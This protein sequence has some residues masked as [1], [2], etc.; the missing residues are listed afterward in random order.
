MFGLEQLDAEAVYRRLPIQL[1]NL[2]C[3]FVGWRTERTR[4]S[5]AF[6][7]IL[8]E[9]VARTYWTTDET[10]SFRSRRLGSLVKTC[11]RTVPF[12]R[13]RLRAAGIAASDIRSIEDL[14]ALPI[15][16]KDE[17]REHLLKLPPTTV[18]SR[19]TRA[20]HTSGTTGAGLRFRTTMV[21]IQEQW[22]IWWRYRGWH[23]IERRTWCGLFGGRSVVP[24]TQKSPPFWRFN[25]AGRQ[26]LF[27]GYHISPENLPAYAAELRRRQP[28]WLHG[29]PSLWTHIPILAT[30]FSG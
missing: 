16:T 13:E 1:Q 9:A 18:L 11:E 19:K 20:V 12:Y 24:A 25:H 29:Y 17:V 27:S 5:G 23:G 8:E 3:T 26:L 6:S 15:L 28:P 14:E 10:A 22:A 30:R 7:R 4:Y 2:A 21:A